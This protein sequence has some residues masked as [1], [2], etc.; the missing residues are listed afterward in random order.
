MSL[1]FGLVVPVVVFSYAAHVQPI[2]LIVA[3][4]AAPE[5]PFEFENSVLIP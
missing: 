4:H 5:L 3:F 1:F 2:A